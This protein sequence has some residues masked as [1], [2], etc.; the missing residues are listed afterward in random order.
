[1]RL[2]LYLL[3][4]IFHSM[5]CSHSETITFQ[6]DLENKFC[7]TCQEAMEISVMGDSKSNSFELYSKD[8][9]VP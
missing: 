1:M 8:E 2:D 4:F 6:R 7:I 3:T 5:N 9:S